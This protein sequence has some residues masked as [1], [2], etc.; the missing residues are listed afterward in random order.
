MNNILLTGDSQVLGLAIL[1]LFL[2]S[3]SSLGI[4]GEIIHLDNETI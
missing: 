2:I 4:I 3:D 1:C